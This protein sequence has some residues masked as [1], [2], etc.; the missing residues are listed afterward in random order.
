MLLSNSVWAGGD[1]MGPATRKLLHW[2]SALIALPAALYAGR[3]FF[4]S[5]L[6]ALK[7]GHANMDVP[8]S[9]AVILALGLSVY[10]FVQGGAHAYFD[11]AVMLLFFLV[12]GRYLDHRLRLRARTAAH[13]LLALQ[14]V[15]AN[16]FDG[17]G[18]AE[19]ILLDDDLEN[20]PVDQSPPEIA[21]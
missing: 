17:D 11:A 2:I 15:T 19:R 4:A 8:I 6:R 21:R 3:P 9:L 7:G 12:I 20:E 10:E 18:A 14:A 1:E 5:A 13:D 16:R